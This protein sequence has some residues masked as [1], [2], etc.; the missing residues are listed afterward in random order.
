MNK[1]TLVGRLGKD[2]EHQ[3]SQSGKTFCKFSI[4]TNDGYG[5][6]KKTNWHNCT[7]FGKVA[8]IINQYVKKGSEIAVSGS[9]DYNKHEDKIYTNVLVNDFT[10]IGGKSEIQS[11]GIKPPFEPASSLVDS[12][13]QDPLPF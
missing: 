1:V 8:D 6:N 4:A 7:A 10:F 2:P 11:E 12:S 3:T 13:D 9:L 5:D